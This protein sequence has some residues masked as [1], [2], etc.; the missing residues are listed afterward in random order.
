M[1]L[2]WFHRDSELGAHTSAILHDI[3][4]YMFYHTLYNS[5][6]ATV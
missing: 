4:Y 5:I 2:Y 6:N 1:V 3:L